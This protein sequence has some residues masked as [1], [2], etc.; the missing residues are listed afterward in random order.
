LPDRFIQA[1]EEHLTAIPDQRE[2][3]NGRAE[4]NSPSCFQ[5]EKTFLTTSQIDAPGFSWLMSAMG[6]AAMLEPGT[7]SA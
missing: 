1:R 2:A 5:V 3:G 6:I 7:V 4:L